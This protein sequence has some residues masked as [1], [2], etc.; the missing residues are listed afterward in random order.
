MKGCYTADNSDL[1]VEVHKVHHISKRTGKI[2]MK[3]TCFYKNSGEICNWITP[4]GSRNLELIYD[5]VKHWKR[6]RK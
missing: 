2:K 5:V 1:Y 4:Y 6:Y 3:A